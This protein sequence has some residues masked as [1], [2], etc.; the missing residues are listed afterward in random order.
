MGRNRGR[1]VHLKRRIGRVFS[2]FKAYGR[3]RRESER[4]RDIQVSEREEEVG[5]YMRRVRTFVER[6]RKR[7]VE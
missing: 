1:H 5:R 7:E 3:R 2:K 4:D 6:K